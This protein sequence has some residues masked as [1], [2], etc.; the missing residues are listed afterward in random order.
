MT[1]KISVCMATY[2]GEKYIKEQLESILPQ[3]SEQDEVIV[4]DDGSSDHT[5]DIV[6]SF[7]D[8]RIKIYKNELENGF[9]K[10]FENA[11]N[12]SSGDLI[13]ICDQDDVWMPDKVKVMREALKTHPFVI[14]DAVVTDGELNVRFE[15]F[16][17]HY[18][19]KSGFL[20]TL[21]KTR[22]SGCCMGFTR[23]FLNKA[24]P[25]P[26]NQDLCPYDYWFAY[27]G[28]IDHEAYLLNIPLIMYRRHEET[29]LHAGEYST[30][31]FKE[32][33]DT[34]IYCMRHLLKR[35]KE[36]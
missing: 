12:H 5:L 27:L 34:R 24:L 7:G 11:L 33:V 32:K 31:T 23:E 10:N 21:V 2:N 1:K 13:F 18:G 25:F 14:H 35:R 16:F 30:R 28:E 15:S 22:Y 19:I 8:E 29:A 9:S 26:D 6:R 17:E 3:L 36:K 20:R 4:S